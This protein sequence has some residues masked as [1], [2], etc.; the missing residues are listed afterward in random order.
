M[1]IPPHSFLVG[2]RHVVARPKTH[3]TTQPG[4]DEYPRRAR[5]QRGVQQDAYPATARTGYAHT[6]ELPARIHVA[7]RKSTEL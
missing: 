7:I 2:P 3:V 6:L 5:A 1:I 4:M